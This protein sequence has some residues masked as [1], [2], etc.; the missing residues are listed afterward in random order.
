[1][2]VGIFLFRSTLAILY[3]D[4]IFLEGNHMICQRFLLGR[5]VC[6]WLI[7][8]PYFLYIK[9]VGAPLD[10]YSLSCDCV[11]L[12]DYNVNHGIHKMYKKDSKAIL[13]MPLNSDLQGTCLDSSALSQL[14]YIAYLS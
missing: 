6:H 8:N 11:S 3:I 14:I 12:T 13:A 9:G 2:T 7:Q 4:L 5:K 10:H 1:M